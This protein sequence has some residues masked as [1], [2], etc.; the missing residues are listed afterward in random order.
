MPIATL[1]IDIEARLAR[2]EE[3]LDRA[4]RINAKAAKDVEAHWLAASGVVRGAFG[5]LTAAFSVD[6]IRSFVLENAKAVDALNDIADATGASVEGIS[7]LQ[8]VARATGTDIAV[9]DT[10]LVKLN[11]ALNSAKPDSD[12]AKALQAIGLSAKDLKTLDPA[13]ALRQI[14][15]ALA[16]FADD[17]N[18]ARLVQ[19]LFGKSLR[20][21]APLLKD[22]ATQTQLV[23]SV[24]KEQAE[25]AER[26]AH[27]L[28]QMDVEVTKFTR[29]VVGAMLP[30]LTDMIKSVNAAR[31][32]FGGLAGAMQF[33]LL[34][35]SEDALRSPLENL[36][37]YRAE[38][39]RAKEAQDAIASGQ[40]GQRFDIFGRD[41][42][43]MA[44]KAVDKLRQYV[45]YY[46][47]LLG[48]TDKAGA[49]RGSVNPPFAPPSVGDPFAEAKARKEKRG[50]PADLDFRRSE[51]ASTEKVNN[52]LRLAQYDEYLRERKER[53][54]AEILQNKQVLEFK[55]QQLIEE[56]ERMRIAA[57]IGVKKQLDEISE[58]AREAQRNIQDAL[59]DTLKRALVGDFK[60]IGDL[61]K[62]L[63]AEMAA[64]AAAARLNEALFGK[65]GG[66]GVLGPLLDSVFRGFGGSAAPSAAGGTTGSGVTV[67]NNY[68]V[69]AGVNRQEL[70]SSL[71]LVAAAGRA[72]TRALL[73]SA[74]VA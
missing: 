65:N 55:D 49:G 71:Q 9:V 2:L 43:A 10:A 21:V 53:I 74:G 30:T 11:Q 56:E 15:V 12:A 66:G 62:N 69:A 4:A 70:V 13:E 1:S 36:E 25:Q 19:E 23:G 58:F 52:D 29:S 42:V 37:K 22:L 57:G 72:D 28:G 32:A 5:A 7:A 8:D 3:G 41:R 48:L 39:E 26:F 24:T 31:E 44:G 27:A 51:I 18:K 16:G 60:S 46:E 34:S 6:A 59:G 64:N 47:R 38:L 20:E 73:R 14:A 17:G 68:N 54:D 63:L 33:S 45:A 40:D 61:W 50:T 35:G 67:V